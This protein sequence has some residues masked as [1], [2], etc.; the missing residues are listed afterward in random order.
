MFNFNRP[1]ESPLRPSRLVRY[2]AA[3]VALATT[4]ALAVTAMPAGAATNHAPI[5]HL[6]A[7]RAE[8][9]GIRI[10]GW[11]ADPDAPHTSLD[12][13]INLGP[14]AGEGDRAWIAHDPRPD[15]AKAYP[16]FGQ[17]HGINLFIAT[18][19]K[20]FS[21]CVAAFDSAGGPSS[22]FGCV[23]VNVPAQHR[24]IGHLD[25]VRSVGNNHITVIG[26]GG[27]L[28]TPDRAISINV[29]LG[30]RYF[31]GAFN[32][33]RLSANQPRPDVGNAYPALG[34]NHGFS[35]TVAARPGTY[36]V[37]GWAFDPYDGGP[38]SLGCITVTV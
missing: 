32:A 1:T 9:G 21:V 7:V 6:D 2:L 19:P 30:S 14:A 13:Q 24:P 4:V 36:P 3:G 10:I 38:T 37:C 22:P 35:L 26:W 34:S 23:Q 20:A 12:L 27:D 25:S 28:D 16:A 5:G 8:P 15:V 33:I 29:L 11:A 17:Y 31:E 18:Q